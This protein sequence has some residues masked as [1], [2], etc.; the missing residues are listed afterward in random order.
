MQQAER[1]RSDRL[2]AGIEAAWGDQRPTQTGR[3]RDLSADG[4][5][6]NSSAAVPVGST[7]IVEVSVP[8]LARVPLAGTVVWAKSTGF[9]VRF[10]KYTQTDRLILDRILT[11][12]AARA[13]GPR[14]APP[15]G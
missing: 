12:L 9:A 4:C 13:G 8:H 15:A 3:I 7:I 10:G 6:I 1:R 2:V 5:F 14:P 11:H